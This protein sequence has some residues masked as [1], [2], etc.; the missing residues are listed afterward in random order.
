MHTNFP[1]QASHFVDEKNEAQK[2]DNSVLTT[3]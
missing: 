3:S 2:D 1:V